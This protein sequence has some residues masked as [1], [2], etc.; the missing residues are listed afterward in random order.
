MSQLG[1]QPY[2]VIVD[3]PSTAALPWSLSAPLDNPLGQGLGQ[4]L[5]Y[6]AIGL[7]LA[8][9]WPLLI[10]TPKSPAVVANV[11]PTLQWLKTLPISLA[12]WVAVEQTPLTLPEATTWDA[13]VAWLHC[14]SPAPFLG[15]LSHAP[16]VSIPMGYTGDLAERI[17]TDLDL[18]PIQ[19]SLGL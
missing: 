18:L 3:T 9:G 2:P 17:E 16:Q 11:W 10:V 12:G 8:L 14:E 15:C 1:Q 7:A 19:L 5:G 13:M 4:G 6:S